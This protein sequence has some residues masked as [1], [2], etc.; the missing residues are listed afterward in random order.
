MNAYISPRV[1]SPRR[2]IAGSQMIRDIDV[3]PSR[4][5]KYPCVFFH[6]AIAVSFFYNR[7]KLP[8]PTAYRYRKQVSQMKCRFLDS[9]DVR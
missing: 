2:N 9:A 7:K 6:S 3:T 5:R 8:K 4:I 1:A